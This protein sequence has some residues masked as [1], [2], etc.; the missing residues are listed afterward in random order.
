MEKILFKDYPN[1]ETL[2]DANNLNTMQDNAEA[3]IIEVDTKNTNLKNQ[4]AQGWY[5]SAEETWT[6]ASVDDPTG[7]IT[8][9]GDKTTKYSLGM[10]IKFT[11]G[12][13][14]IY[15]IITAIS[16][17]SPNT[18]LTFLHEID[19]TDS[20][21]LYLMQDSAITNTYY[22]NVKTPYGF[23]MQK[24]KWRLLKNYTSDALQ[25][26]AGAGTWYNLGSVYL[27]VPVGKW[28]LGY[29]VTVQ[30]GVAGSSSVNR[31]ITTTISTTNNGATNPEYNMQTGLVGSYIRNTF[32]AFEEKIFT[33]TTRWYLNTM[34]DTAVDVIY[35]LGGGKP[36]QIIA[37]CAYL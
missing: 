4:V 3:S 17:T 37:D 32:Q 9:S 22:S 13:N 2:I 27:D 21:A 6:Y 7:V 10:R 18:T 30:N 1:I 29:K 36:T 11:N 28:D 25:N 19:P 12:G 23:P 33:S 8:I 34:S 20:Q 15:G 5:N 14:V 35:N 26:S 31:V 16:Y 24:S